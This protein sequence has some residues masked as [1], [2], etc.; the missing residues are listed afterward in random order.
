MY[1]RVIIVGTWHAL[2]T[3]TKFCNSGWTVQ[4][5]E[6]INYA[7]TVFV[8]IKCIHHLTKG[9]KYRNVWVILAPADMV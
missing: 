2:Y 9:F 6:E 7:A 1:I 4:V 5:V 3:S 8:N